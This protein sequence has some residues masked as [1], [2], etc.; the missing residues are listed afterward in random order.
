M[1]TSNEHVSN[2]RE[3][4]DDLPFFYFAVANAAKSP[5]LYIK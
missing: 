3:V 4:F 1:K 5:S 2:N